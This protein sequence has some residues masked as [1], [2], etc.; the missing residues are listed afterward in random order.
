M[1]TLKKVLCLS[2]ALLLLAVLFT[3]CGEKAPIPST[4]IPAAMK[5]WWPT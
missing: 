3:A 1:R 2:L 5:R 4:P